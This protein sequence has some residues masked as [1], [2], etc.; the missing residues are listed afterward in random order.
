MQSAKDIET[1]FTVYFCWFMAGIYIHIPFCRQACTYC[2]FHFSVHLSGMEPMVAAIEKEIRQASADQFPNTDDALTIDTI[3][4]GGGTPGL[5]SPPLLNRLLA[6]IYQR[7]VVQSGAEITL[8]TNPDDH[9]TEKL[10]AWKR[11]GIN[12]LSIGVQSFYEDDLRWMNRVHNAGQSLLAIQAAQR[13]GFHNLT[14]DLIYGTP[15]LTD[16]RWLHNLQQATALGVQH[17]SCYALTV[18]PK[19]ALA[20]QIHKGTTQNV[21]ADQQASQFLLLTDWAAQNGFEH[22]EI[23]NLAK[24]G[25]RS[26]HNSAYWQGKPYWG[27]GP[28]AHSFDGYT[29]RWWNIA[30]NTL[31]QKLIENNLPLYEEEI[32]T[33]AQ[34]LNEYVMTAL[35]TGEGIQLRDS[36]WISADLNF[37]KQV[38]KAAA[39]W[40]QLEKLMVHEHAI[41]LT[42][43]GRLYADGIAA[44][45]FV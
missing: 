36:R 43:P 27:F 24:P 41:Q 23:S 28:S 33:P 22:Y 39:K 2:N 6:A 12:R 40:Q 21:N 29:R 20:A 4:F 3:Y 44:D 11:A 45:L 38:L 37:Q 42:T 34:Q 1:F 13:A 8:E 16:E 30:N 9:S 5:L 15:Q 32:L 10:L 31:Y 17:L 18:E 35:R 25:H 19:T 14:I 26:R 7:F